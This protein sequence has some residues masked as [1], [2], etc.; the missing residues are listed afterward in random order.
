MAFL[1]PALLPTTVPHETKLP[2]VEPK[3]VY[4]AC[5]TGEPLLQFDFIQRSKLHARCALPAGLFEQVRWANV[6]G[7]DKIWSMPL[8]DTL[9]TA[10]CLH[11]YRLV[12]LWR[13]FVHGSR[14]LKT[15]K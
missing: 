6:A 14:V 2:A 13:G 5:Y 15:V 10:F 1:V 7:I 3:T 9:C 4:L 11:R 12:S 8:E